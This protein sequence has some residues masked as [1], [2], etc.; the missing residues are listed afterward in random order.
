ME[1]IAVPTFQ[2]DLSNQQV[3]RNDFCSSPARRMISTNFPASKDLDV[4]Q[5]ILSQN[6]FIL[7]KADSHRLIHLKSFK[8]SLTLKAMNNILSFQTIQK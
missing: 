3:P 8:R 1:N 5:K 4:L 2:Q 7:K 6:L